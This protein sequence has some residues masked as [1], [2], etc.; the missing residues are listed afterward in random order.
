MTNRKRPYQPRN[1][2]VDWTIRL[3][4]C[5]V[6]LALFGIG[7]ALLLQSDLGAAPWDVFHQGVS[8]LTGIS[9]GNVIVLTGLLLLLVWIPL[10]QR[11]GEIGRA[12]V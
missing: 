8:E 10:H 2:G 7:I 6:G 12:H 3:T 4:R 5:I 11:P 1:A 9:I